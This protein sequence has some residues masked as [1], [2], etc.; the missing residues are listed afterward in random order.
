MIPA[1][2]IR[3]KR[4]GNELSAE[5]IGFLVSGITDGGL[6]DAQVGALAMALFLRGM[7]AGE[8]V[9][10]TA[11]MTRSGTVMEWDLDRPVIEYVE[12]PSPN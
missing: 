10:L 2:V 9:A 11:A 5:E 1:E 4:D 8:R 12:A 7:D 6:S 3:R